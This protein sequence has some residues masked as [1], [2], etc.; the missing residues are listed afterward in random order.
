MQKRQQPCETGTS[1]SSQPL[2]RRTVLKGAL[3]SVPLWTA[4]PTLLLP[5]KA[6]AASHFGPSTSSDPYLFPSVPGVELRA[7]LTVGDFIDS[8]R[9]VGVP[10]GLGAFH[11][12]GREFTLLMNH[13]LGGTS[14]VVRSHGSKGAFV[15]RW[16]IDRKTLK[17][18]RGQDFSQS[19]NDVYSWDSATNAYPRGSTVW[20]IQGSETRLG[21]FATIDAPKLTMVFCL[22]WV[23][24]KLKCDLLLP[25]NDDSSPA[26]TLSR[27]PASNAVSV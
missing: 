9:M 26:D 7:I 8:Y 21:I 1:T 12:H 22:E 14:G 10:D 24:H 11:S 27:E 20:H 23:R 13:E 17:V 16:T 25:I 3:I 18:S 2:T 6:V 15:S 19:P 4:A 5:R